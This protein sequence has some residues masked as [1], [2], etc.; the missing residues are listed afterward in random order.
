M[1]AVSAHVKATLNI[2]QYQRNSDSCK[3]ICQ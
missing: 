1:S 2:A 3:A